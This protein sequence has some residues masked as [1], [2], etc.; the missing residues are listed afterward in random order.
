MMS[1]LRPAFTLVAV[2]TVLLGL[3]APLAMT[4]LA[5][6]AL[7]HQAGGSLVLREGRIVGSA[8]IGQDFT[9]PR[10]VHP[11][12]S[13]TTEPDP[14]NPGSTRAAPY[15]AAASAASQLGPSSAVLL[16]AVRGRVA[17]RGGAPVPADAVTASGS[18]LDPHISVENARAQVAR[19]AAARGLPR[20]Q[21]A[22]LVESMAE[23]RLLGVLG[24]RRVNVLRLNLALD[25]R[26]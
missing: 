8:L 23:G 20:E 12:P 5:G 22:R 11:R 7:P 18:G 6:V 24:E 2:F 26:P 1:L 10:Y 16:E 21:V 15:N 25:A 9:A 4:G 3:A 17:V 19:V 13:A 14:D